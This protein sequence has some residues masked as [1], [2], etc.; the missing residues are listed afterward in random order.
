L[1]SAP[2]PVWAPG[3]ASWLEQLIANLLTNAL[4]HSP[5]GAQIEVSIALDGSEAAC[6][7]ADRGPGVSPDDRERIFER[8]VQSGARRGRLGLGLYICKKIVALHGGRIWVEANP[9]GGACFA[10]CLPLASIGGP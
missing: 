10:F 6:R 3:N 1:T 2:N 7:V 9:G 8:F 5:P 4:R